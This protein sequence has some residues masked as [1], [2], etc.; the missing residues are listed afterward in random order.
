MDAVGDKAGVNAGGRVGAVMGISS[1]VNHKLTK[2]GRI[3]GHPN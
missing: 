1:Q 3:R 2:L